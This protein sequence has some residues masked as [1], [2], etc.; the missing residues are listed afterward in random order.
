VTLD[1][2]NTITLGTVNTL[3]GLTVKAGG[4]VDFKR[5]GDGGRRVGRGYD[6]QQRAAWAGNITDTGAG[7]LLITGQRR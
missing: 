6:G 4:A 1:D 7:K 2:A 5:C 3:A